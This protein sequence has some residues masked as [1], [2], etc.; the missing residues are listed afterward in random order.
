VEREHAMRVKE[1]HTMERALTHAIG[2]KEVA[3]EKAAKVV[4]LAFT[5]MARAA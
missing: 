1:Q 4:K 5:R 3:W 2:R